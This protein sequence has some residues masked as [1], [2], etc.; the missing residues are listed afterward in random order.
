MYHF[1][2]HF[3]SFYDLCPCKKRVLCEFFVQVTYLTVCLTI[4]IFPAAKCNLG[5]SLDNYQLKNIHHSMHCET[6]Y[7]F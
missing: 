6:F 7:D 1:N 3:C 5:L 4:L 2:R